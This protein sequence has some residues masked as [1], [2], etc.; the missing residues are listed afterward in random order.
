MNE[1]ENILNAAKI[2]FKKAK[3]LENIK[4]GYSH[5]IYS[6][7]TGEY[8]PKVIIK[9]SNNAP[10]ENSLKK[11]IRINKLLE[12]KGFPVPKIILHDESKKIVPFEFVIM[13]YLEGENLDSIFDKLHNTEK[14]DI[15]EQLGDLMGRIHGIK[16]D[17]FGELLPEGILE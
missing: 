4:R 8:P 7:E 3:N 2:I 15:F 10:P 13:T 11:E 14:E 9:L 12:K 17:K 6:V 1:P 5:E 16:F